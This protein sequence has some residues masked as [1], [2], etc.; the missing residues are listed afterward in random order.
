MLFKI[1]KL[2]NNKYNNNKNHNNSNN[3]KFNI[4]NKNMKETHQKLIWIIWIIVPQKIKYILQ[5]NN[6]MMR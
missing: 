6:K 2:K 4:N 1:S 5:N 3:N